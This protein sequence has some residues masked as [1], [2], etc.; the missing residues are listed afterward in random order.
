MGRTL[1]SLAS[2]VFDPFA[3]SGN[4]VISPTHPTVG[5]ATPA[6]R[7]GLRSGDIGFFLEQKAFLAYS[8]FKAGADT[9]VVGRLER[10]LE[11]LALKTGLAEVL[12]ITWRSRGPFGSRYC[13]FLALVRT[14]AVSDLNKAVFAAVIKGLFHF[15]NLLQGLEMFLLFSEQLTLERKEIVLSLEN[16]II[17]LTDNCRHLV[18]VANGHGRFTKIAREAEGCRSSTNKR[19]IHGI[20][21]IV[22]SLVVATTILLRDSNHTAKE[23]G[24]SISRACPFGFII[25]AC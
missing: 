20:P 5:A 17:Q 15:S 2:T 23:K 8:A 22:V 12:R 24:K 13:G 3:G 9:H 11:T 14:K 4:V 16:L 7:S 21:A 1:G 19:K 10:G 18:E 6:R 25:A